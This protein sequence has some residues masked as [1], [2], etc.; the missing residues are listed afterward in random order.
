L[1]I[2]QGE[3]GSVD[4]LGEYR[5]KVSARGNPETDVNFFGGTLFT[6]QTAESVGKCVYRTFGQ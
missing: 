2:D 4:F 3:E 6:E 1:P 5:E